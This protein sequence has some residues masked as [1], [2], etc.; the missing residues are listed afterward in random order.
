M[1][2]RTSDPESA[3]KFDPDTRLKY[4]IWC[5]LFDGYF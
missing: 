3:R 1:E 2:K 4:A 5:T